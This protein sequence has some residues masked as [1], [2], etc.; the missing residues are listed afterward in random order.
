MPSAL[1]SLTT[2]TSWSG[3]SLRAV[4]SAVIT[5]L[6]IVPLSLYAGKNMLS[7]ASRGRAACAW[8][9]AEILVG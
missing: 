2:M 1:P 5:R 7:P 8:R 9:T 3:V 6:A 4:R